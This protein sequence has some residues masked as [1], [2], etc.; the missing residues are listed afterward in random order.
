MDYTV[1]GVAKCHTRLSNFHF[2]FPSRKQSEFTL[3]AALLNTVST[4][5]AFSCLRSEP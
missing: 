1:H 5:L 3:A 4:L 2:P